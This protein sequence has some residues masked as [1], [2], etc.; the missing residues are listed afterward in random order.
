MD[1]IATKLAKTKQTPE[2]AAAMDASIR[3]AKRSVDA[4]KMITDFRAAQARGLE[5]HVIQL[6]LSH[7]EQE[8]PRLFAML[9]DP[10]CS[11]AMLNAMLAQLEA[12]E[13][14]RRSAHEASV[15]VGTTLVNSF[16]RP[17]L[18]MAPVPLPDS[19]QPPARSTKPHTGGS[20]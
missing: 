8:Y 19:Q 11:E 14:G 2:E 17:K 16:V 10:E 4:R 20:R 5:P 6:E 13:S 9:N 18:G 1:S 7:W 12:V 3:E 15:V